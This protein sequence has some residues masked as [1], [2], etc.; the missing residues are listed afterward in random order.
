MLST[1]R[2]DLGRIAGRYA[3]IAVPDGSHGIYIEQVGN[4]I[5]VILLHNADR[6]SRQYQAQLADT[7]LE[8]GFRFI[9]FD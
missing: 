3:T 2:L 4:G 9:A 5:P 1:T 6:D 7:E 8:R